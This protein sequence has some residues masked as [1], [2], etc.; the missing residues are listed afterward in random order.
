MGELLY[1]VNS[2]PSIKTF[3]A[4]M[5]VDAVF[6]LQGN[7]DLNN[8]QLIKKLGGSMTD[9]FLAEGFILQKTIGVNQPKKIENAKIL[10]ANTA[11]DTDKIKI[12]GSKVRVD[13]VS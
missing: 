1:L 8:I 4:K 2:S 9:S 10:L 5:A 11:M 3:F 12:F 7:G 6:R 13:Q